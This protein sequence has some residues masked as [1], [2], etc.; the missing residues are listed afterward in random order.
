MKRRDEKGREILVL[1]HKR[2]LEISKQYFVASCLLSLILLSFLVR[3]INI[4]QPFLKHHFRQS[5]TAITVWSFLQD[6]VTPLAYETPVL[7][8]PWQVPFEF[9]TFQLSAF[10]L[11][12]V[13]DLGL[14]T[15][16]RLTSLFYFYLSALLLYLLCRAALKERAVVWMTTLFYLWSPFTVLWSRSC[17]IDYA[18]VAMALG[19]LLLFHYWVQGQRGLLPVLAIIILGCLS[20]LTKITTMAAFAP[21][22]ILFAAKSCLAGL[23]SFG[24]M[25]SY[26]RLKRRELISLLCFILFPIAVGYLYTSYTDQIKAASPF[27]AALT[28]QGLQGW[29]FGALSMRL[30]LRNWLVIAFRLVTQVIP[31]AFFVMPF[32]ALCRLGQYSVEERVFLLG[33]VAGVCLPIAVFFNL[34]VV[35]DYYLIA[36]SP[37]L[38]LLVGVGLDSTVRYVRAQSSSVRIM[39]FAIFIV[40][41]VFSL[42]EG[43]EFTRTI[44]TYNKKPLYCQ[45]GETLQRLTD[46][47]EHIMITDFQWD[48][49]ILYYSRRKGFM[50]Y[51]APPDEKFPY[52]FLK[53]NGFT[54]V[55]CKNEYP[56]LFSAWQHRKLLDEVGDFRIYRVSD[57][58]L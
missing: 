45:I 48:S 40:L 20:Y 9:P 49:S 6:D 47:R 11:A 54:V 10:L 43:S 34:Y 3:L 27:T 44:M 19:Y 21:W 30:E 1:M 7:G 38:S 52:S 29:N 55:V 14:D 16:C 31:Y 22:V 41:G 4:N 25:A 35:H 13:T 57:L 50:F 36:I 17:M 33:A 37:L 8:P 46:P 5:Q 53:Q 15:V 32:V 28:S 12:N 18:S 23:R 58:P 56:A 24:N 42:Y 2:W 26:V 39:L 51:F